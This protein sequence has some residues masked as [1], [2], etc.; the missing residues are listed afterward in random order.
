MNKP[1]KI[2]RVIKDKD[3]PYV[4][5]NKNP[6]DD[7]NLSWQA[8]GLLCYLLS[9]PD[10]WE[11]FLSDLKNRSTNGRDS[12]ASIL[13]ELIKAGYISR[14]KKENKGKF[15]GY[16]YTV[17]EKKELN[18][19]GKTVTENPTVL[20][21]ELTN[22]ISRNE[23]SDKNENSFP[24]KQEEQP[25]KQEKFTAKSVIAKFLD[26]YVAVFGVAYQGKIAG[27]EAGS[28]KQIT[29]KV[30]SC[31]PETPHEFLDE[32]L[33]VAFQDNW[34][35]KNASLSVLNSTKFFNQC[36]RKVKQRNIDPY[37]NLDKVSAI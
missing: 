5:I 17:F 11:I 3:N 8:K 30:L 21:N 9:K 35:Y 10:D 32:L 31:E 12:T 34:F 27:K 4:I 18:R 15:R 7:V 14:T 6:L 13:N 37:A 20:Y 28:A 29:K 1:K 22:N 26:S 25:S 24:A 33:E 2:I 19:I 36:V 23:T 16:D